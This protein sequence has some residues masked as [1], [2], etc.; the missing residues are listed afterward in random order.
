MI[1]NSGFS[2]ELVPQDIL[3]RYFVK[4]SSTYGYVPLIGRSGSTHYFYWCEHWDTL[5]PVGDTLT[6][7]DNPSLSFT[8]TQHIQGSTSDDYVLVA[9]GSSTDDDLE[10]LPLHTYFYSQDGGSGS[11]FTLN[12]AYP[13]VIT[14]GMSADNSTLAWSH[15]KGYQMAANNGRSLLSYIQV[16]GGDSGKANLAISS[17]TGQIMLI[18]S[19]QGYISGDQTNLQMSTVYSIVP[20]YILGEGMTATNWNAASASEAGFKMIEEGYLPWDDSFISASVEDILLASSSYTYV[21]SSETGSSSG[22]TPP[23]TGSIANANV[24]IKSNG[25]FVQ[26]DL[27]KFVGSNF[28][29]F[30]N[31]TLYST[32][33]GGGG[34]GT[35][36]TIEYMDSDSDPSNLPAY[37]FSGMSIGA[38]AG[39]DVVAVAVA[40][41]GAAAYDIDYITI[42]GV[43]ASIDVSIMNGLTGVAI[44]SATGVTG[45]TADIYVDL[46]GGVSRCIAH[47]YRISNLEYNTVRETDFNQFGDSGTM[48]L[49]HDI[50]GSSAA[51]VLSAC[52]GINTSTA[53]WDLLDNDATTPQELI[54][55]HT[56]ASGGFDSYSDTVTLSATGN[57]PCAVSTVFF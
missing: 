53:T 50:T 48:T 15:G 46:A 54:A 49:T 41:R 34:G 55:L 22:S 27:Y 38:E 40:W 18:G 44:A 29:D 42:G 23:A 13:F 33:S 21:S 2:E 52:V 25:S 31:N 57:S 56:A 11:G 39:R 4:D 5:I 45:T 19:N 32:G 51:V 9:S 24:Y 7:L 26:Q 43:T 8:V 3:N 14:T 36:P 35:L 47:T 28:Y 16:E 37:T 6:D 12:T 17:T 20:Q 10:V 1:F 30:W